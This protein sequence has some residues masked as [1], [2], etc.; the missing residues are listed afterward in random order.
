MDRVATTDEPMSAAQ[1]TYLER[2]CREQGEDFDPTV[3]KWDASAA[4]QRLRAAKVPAKDDVRAV[5]CG[6]CG[7]DA[8]EPCREP[9]GVTRE[10]HH[11]GRVDRLLW[12]RDAERAI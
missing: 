11:R 9:D 3:S 5:A 4:I 12:Q 8:A 6:T 10:A 7:V 2:L 1:A